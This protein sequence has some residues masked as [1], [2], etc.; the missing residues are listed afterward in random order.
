MSA[1]RLSLLCAAFCALSLMSLAVGAEPGYT[2]EKGIVY[3]VR[4]GVTLVMDMKTRDD[5]KKRKPCCVAIHGGGWSEGTVEASDWL[6]APLAD[7]GYTVFGIT[8]RLAPDH[9]FP[10]QIE[11]CKCAVRFIRAN[12]KKYNIDPRRI[13]AYGSSA[14]GH[15]ASLLGVLPEGVYEG[16][17][18]YQKYSSRADL[19]INSLGP[20]DMGFFARVPGSALTG[21]YGYLFDLS[22]KDLSYWTAKASP[23]SYVSRRSAPHLL[24]YGGRDDLVYPAQGELFYNKLRQAG[25][26]AEMHVSPESGHG[27]PPEFRMQYIWP[28]L[29]KFFGEVK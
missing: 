22:G 13:V 27:P 14:G 1:L 9:R 23:S 21:V 6:G 2:E 4:D 15:L 25:V 7:M 16:K 28:F 3:D 10:A 17:G 29:S 19:V 11:D 18:P 26:Y 24:L 5:G 12:A 20:E 8:Y